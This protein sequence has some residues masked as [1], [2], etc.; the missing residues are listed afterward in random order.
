MSYKNA[1]SMICFAFCTTSNWGMLKTR[2]F[3]QQATAL[4][5]AIRNLPAAA[6]SAQ[7]NQII[8]ACE[9]IE[10]EAHLAGNQDA[11]H[12]FNRMALAVS[13]RKLTPSQAQAV[14]ESI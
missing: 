11:S 14:E 2:S 10:R 5:Q 4:A 12:A 3:K 13:A 9:A 6:T 7:L 1:I 8:E